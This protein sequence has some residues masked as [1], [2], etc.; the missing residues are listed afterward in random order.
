MRHLPE[1]G[2]GLHV[3]DLFLLA[4][5]AGNSHG[6]ISPL[7]LYL[8]HDRPPA[9]S[10]NFRLLASISAEEW[11][12][13]GKPVDRR[14]LPLDWLLRFRNDVVSRACREQLR[15][16]SRRY[17]AGCPAIATTWNGCR[18]PDANRRWGDN[19]P[20]GQRFY[21]DRRPDSRTSRTRRTTP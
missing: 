17:F 1:S 15:R 12:S 18:F 7:Y 19:L 16:A 4:V 2:S 14:S 11:R 10:C 3:H 5:I 9:S 21:A 6:D 13:C 8:G 20:S